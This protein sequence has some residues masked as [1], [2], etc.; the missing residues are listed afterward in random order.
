MEKYRATTHVD[1]TLLHEL[2]L[3]EWEA[4]VVPLVENFCNNLIRKVHADLLKDRE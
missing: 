3:I 1:Q 2:Y 4:R